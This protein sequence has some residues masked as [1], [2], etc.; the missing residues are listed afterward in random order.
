[1]SVGV[2]LL[3]ILALTGAALAAV[4]GTGP[5]EVQGPRQGFGRMMGGIIARVAD[6]LGI[7]VAAVQEARAEGQ[8]LADILGDKTEAF[9]AAT[10][11][12]RQ[13]FLAQMVESG[14]I[15]AE[16]AALCED[17]METRL[18]ER[19][20]A[21]KFGC[22]EKVFGQPR[23]QMKKMVQQRMMQRRQNTNKPVVNTG[24]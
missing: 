24:T 5:G 19:L 18:T 12:E 1:M 13:E 14:K 15:T 7:E 9:V 3:L 23:M 6:F 4:P 20:N 17:Q 2:A 22:G 21:E 16:Q 8:T 10:I 11:A